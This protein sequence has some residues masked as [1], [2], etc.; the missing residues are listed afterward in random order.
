MEPDW[1]QTGPN[2]LLKKKIR[3]VLTLIA[4]AIRFP[5]YRQAGI[6][7]FF[8]KALFASYTKSPYINSN[9]TRNFGL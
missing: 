6:P 8:S 3:P 1:R 9:L 7:W 5:A 4:K 2:V